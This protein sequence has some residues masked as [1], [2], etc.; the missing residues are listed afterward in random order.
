MIHAFRADASLRIGSGHVMRC[1]TLADRL[2]E[3]GH[4]CV[5]VSR[6]LDGNLIAAVRERGHAAEVLTGRGEPYAAGESAP[7]H[8]SWLECA[9]R[10]DAL[11]TRAVLERVGARRLIVDHYALD[12]RWE[13]TVA[14]PGLRRMGL[15]D[16]ADR[17]RSVELLLDQNLGR[18]EAHYAGLVPATCRI[19]AGPQHALVGP[20][21]SQLRATS[22]QRRQH[23]LVRRIMLSMGG[24]DSHDATSAALACLNAAHLPQGASVLVV[25]GRHAPRLAHVRAAAERMRVPVE[26][27][28]DVRDMAERMS[29]CDLAIGGAGGTAWERCALGLP[30]IAVVLAENQRSGALA[31][32]AAGAALTIENLAELPQAL[33]AQLE[34]VMDPKLLAQLSRNAAAVTDGRGA[35]RVCDALEAL[36]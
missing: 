29:D 2:R 26:V 1:L 8:A 23:P 9:W 24:V 15:D 4:E 5:F 17:P 33:P 11:A 28:V 18:S 14:T 25:M 20:R 36:T 19:L 21:F 13:E 32:A 6:D 35:E 22:L 30:T 10:E 3:R 31:L 34:R 12:A 27:A 7:F 16:L